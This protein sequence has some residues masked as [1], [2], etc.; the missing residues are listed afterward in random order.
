[1]SSTARDH[2]ASYPDFA[3]GVGL[4]ALRW[5]SAGYGCELT[6]SDVFMAAGYAIE[7]ARNAGRADEVINRIRAMI[8][9][10]G[11]RTGGGPLVMFP[12]KDI[13]P[14]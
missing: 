7:A 13:G 8:A 12:G 10:E 2:G 3:L 9:E 11:S 14:V 4:A 5:I 1:M 6:G